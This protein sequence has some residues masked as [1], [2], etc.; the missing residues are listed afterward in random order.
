MV[1]RTKRGSTAG[2]C[3]GG[4]KKKRPPENKRVEKVSYAVG[5]RTKNNRFTVSEPSQRPRT[6]KF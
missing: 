4:G 5:G 1:Q 6:I 2:M 3:E